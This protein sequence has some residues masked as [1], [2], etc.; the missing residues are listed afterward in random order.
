MKY[1]DKSLRKKR[2]RERETETFFQSI[3]TSSK[4]IKD[5]SQLRVNVSK[6]IVLKT[7]RKREKLKKD[8][9]NMPI[10]LHIHNIYFYDF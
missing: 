9:L 5:S 6:N 1:V 3:D 4:I 10:E 2:D 7:E 8:K